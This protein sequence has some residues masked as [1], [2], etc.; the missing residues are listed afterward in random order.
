MLL[1]KV[2]T[3]DIPFWGKS[4][5]QIA[6]LVKSDNSFLKLDLNINLN[7]GKTQEDRQGSC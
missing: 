1:T 3:C 4:A 2:V 7:Y 6:S 5:N